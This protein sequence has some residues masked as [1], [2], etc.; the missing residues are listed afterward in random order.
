VFSSSGELVRT[1]EMQPMRGLGYQANW[2]GRDESGELLPA[3]TYL[4]R[5]ESPAY[6]ETRKVLL[7]R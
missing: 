2:N 5:V 4:Y 3:G 7:T 6:T 1:L